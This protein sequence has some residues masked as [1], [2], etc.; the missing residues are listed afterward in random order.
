ML[1]KFSTD[2][3]QSTLHGAGIGIWSWDVVSDKLSWSTRVGEVYG[4]EPVDYPDNIEAFSKLIASPSDDL[5]VQIFEALNPETGRFEIEHQVE[6]RDGSIG[7]VRNSGSMELGECNQP[8]KL[9]VAAMDITS[10]KET[11]LSLQNREEQ[12]RRFSQLTS[13][14]L[15]ETDMTVSP[16]VPSIVAGSYE[17]LVG[18][19]PKELAEQGGWMGV[20]NP[21]DRVAAE[22]VWNRLKAGFPTV[23]DYRITNRD[24]ETRWLRDHSQPILKDGEL[25]RVIGGV[26][27]ITETKT[28]QEELLQAQKHEAVAHLAGAVAHDFNNLMCVV[29][30]STELMSMEED[31]SEREELQSEVLLACDR[32]TELTR[33]LLTFS[34]KDLPIT[35]VV[36]LSGTLE[37][38][39]SL[40]QRAVGGAIKLNMEYLPNVNDKVEIDPGHLQLVLLNLA[41]NARKAMRDHGELNISVAEVDSHSVE[42]PEMQVGKY[43]LLEISDTG[44]GIPEENLDRVFEPFFTTSS[45]GKGFGIGLA[46]C[47]QI[48]EQ[49]G[50]TIRARG[51]E[52]RGATFT[53]YLPAVNTAA[54]PSQVSTQQFTIG[55]KER[56][57]VVEDD[58]AVRR[59]SEHTLKSL[60]YEVSGAGSV[61]AAH[62]EMART[63]FDLLLVDIQLPDGDGC[64]L[65]SELR[66]TAP[67]LPALLV[68]GHVND[69]VRERVRTEGHSILPKPFSINALARSVRAT[70]ETIHP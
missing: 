50:G 61:Q 16:L 5:R 43:A 25:T 55:G 32:A 26:K 64:S 46:T 10:Q 29:V 1:S 17:R 40:L 41:T 7:W 33:S 70:L 68:S 38:T 44:C 67:G 49:A 47:R 62:Q 11:E 65:V 12:F 36:R 3:W 57:L 28:L 42:L 9:I 63:A 18:Y 48:V 13:D 14:Y 23:H 21:D 39:R 69:E 22:A 60:G 45:D 59:V 4:L 20:I 30:G 8:E 24:G 2:E 27:D 31:E 34:G 19:S 54:S 52:E 35:Q 53:V 56:I 66:K 51:H 6:R 58:L 15:Y 37:N